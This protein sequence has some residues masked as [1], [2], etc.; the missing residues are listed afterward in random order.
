MA[1]AACWALLGWL[2]LESVVASTGATTKVPLQRQDLT[3]FNTT[4]LAQRIRTRRK[5]RAA[6][7]FLSRWW[8]APVV[9]AQEEE[10]AVERLRNHKNLLY[11]GKVDIGEP[12]Q[13]VTL[14][15]D[16]GSSDLWVSDK[17]FTEQQSYTWQPTDYNVA[18][19]YG[20]GSVA[21]YYG[22]DKVCLQP[23][24]LPC[25]PRQPIMLATVTLQIQLDYMDGILG[26]GFVGISH[27]HRT[28]L[29][30][31]NESF[32][33]LTF[34]FQ[35]RPDHSEG[36]S[37]VYFGEFDEVMAQGFLETGIAKEQ[38]LHAQV[39]DLF[40]IPDMQH[41]QA[42]WW[43]AELRAKVMGQPKNLTS[44]RFRFL[45]HSWLLVAFLLTCAYLSQR[46]CKIYYKGTGRPCCD[47]CCSTLWCLCYLLG[48]IYLI[49]FFVV[50]F[51]VGDWMERPVLA[52]FDT[53]TSLI[54]MPTADFLSVA[55]TMF[56]EKYFTDCEVVRGNLVCDCSI[57]PKVRPLVFEFPAGGSIVLRPSEMFVKV[58]Q[59]HDM[60]LC[61]T[62]LAA[63]PQPIWILGDVFL[64][65]VFAV[66]AFKRRE[67]ALFPYH[68][69][70]VAETLE[71]WGADEG[72][73]ATTVAA[74]ATL[75]AAVSA[76]WALR[77]GKEPEKMAEPL[78]PPIRPEV[79]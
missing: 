31:L 50:V 60:E 8:P 59:T 76:L 5:N 41:L 43:L 15:F 67:V 78:L 29:R 53:G 6:A 49:N 66:H 47:C 38:V 52:A 68:P 34:A 64:R 7:S 63:N 26:L 22:T 20:S 32:Q 25:I 73:A 39:L 37:F 9:D 77:R 23:S 3:N 24:S 55:S 51:S 65:Q 71:T 72:G 14:V 21:G 40:K 4:D 18:I 75:V 35:L 1:T 16:T 74:V 58:G 70:K 44:L 30:N 45:L 36:G 12:A 57:A 69:E 48:A 28:F 17:A 27:V 11:V 46:Y 62:G 33:D 19:M 10:E 79:S 2:L 13:E 42:G 56:G 54:S 61:L